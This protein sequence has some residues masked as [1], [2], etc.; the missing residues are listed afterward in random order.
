M[1]NKLNQPNSDTALPASDTQQ[2][3]PDTQDSF[4]ASQRKE[5]YR[6]FTIT[7]GNISEGATVETLT[8][9][10]ANIDIPAIIIGENGRGRSRG[11]LPVNLLGEDYQKWKNGDKP[12]IYSAE[13]GNTKAGK[14]KLFTA[15]SPNTTGQILAV[16]RT[17]IGYR[18]SNNHTGDRAGWRCRNFECKASEEGVVEIPEICPGCGKNGLWSGPQ[19]HFDEFPGKQLIEGVI[20]QGAAGRAGSGRQIIAIIPRDTVFRTSYSGRLY[21]APSA[22]YYK[23]DGDKLISATW[24]E[25]TA[26]DIF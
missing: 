25:R 22:H 13:V 2:E 9:K 1:T 26:A 23:W 14:P 20:A 6:I 7:S 11:V 10:G 24:E 19:L 16:L 3:A 8:L 15:E 4:I 12:V 18:G 17:R 5:I 21:G